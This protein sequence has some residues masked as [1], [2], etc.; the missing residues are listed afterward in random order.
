MQAMFNFN[1]IL[2]LVSLFAFY[3]LFKKIF[4]DGWISLLGTVSAVSLMAFPILKYTEFTK[5]LVLPVFLY[6]LY[7]FF[8]EQNRNNSIFLGLMYGIMALSHSTAFIFS[9]LSI[10]VIFIYLLYYD[11]Q[12]FKLSLPYVQSKKWFIIAFLIGFIIAQIYWFEPIFILHGNTKLASQLWST[13]DFSSSSVQFSF[14]T[15]TLL[16]MFFNTGSIFAFVSGLLTLAG[17]VFF[18]NNYKTLKSSEMFVLLIFLIAFILTF[19]YFITMPLLGTNFVPGYIFDLYLRVAA[20]GVAMFGLVNIIQLLGQ[21]GKYLIPIMFVLFVLSAYANYDAWYKGKFEYNPDKGIPELYVSLQGFL[22]NDG[23]HGS[24]LTSNELGFAINALTGKDLVATRRAHNDPFVDFD[25]YQLDTA[26]ILYGN[27]LETKKELLKKYNVKYL[28]ADANW[29]SMEW[30]VQDG[31]IAGYSDPLLMF[32]SSD[33][34]AILVN[35]GIKY[36]KLKGWADPAVRGMNVKTYDLLIISPE[37]Y[38]WTGKGPWKD[39]IDVLLTDSWDYKMD[40]QLVAALFQV[41]N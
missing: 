13:E 4:N 14:L 32:Y 22:M 12:N 1:L 37:N 26:I 21:H 28:Y 18:F 5:Y 23:V 33:K 6:S 30:M 35:N 40:G 9:S 34:E 29:V 11:R 10:A 41:S 16:D 17:V 24:V 31:K 3:F 36:V 15:N 27:N 7:L 38:D 19:S 39:D 25:Q 8:T 2:P 20:V